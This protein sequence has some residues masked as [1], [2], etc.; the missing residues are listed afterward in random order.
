M[1]ISPKNPPTVISISDKVVHDLM[2][3]WLE[4]I[5]K[6]W[7]SNVEEFDT[8]S[9]LLSEALFPEP[10]RKVLLDPLVKRAFI[11]PDT[12]LM[13][14]PIDQLPIHDDN[15]GSTL[16]LYERISVSILSSPR[17]I[18]CDATAAKFKFRICK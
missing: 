18:L 2:Q 13:S 3:K 15:D 7:Q 10:V 6:L 17:E 8:I 5:Y 12:D 9:K 16:P 4:A 1:V 14:F 11:S